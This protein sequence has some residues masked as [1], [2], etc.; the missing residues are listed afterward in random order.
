MSE[1]AFYLLK[2]C[3]MLFA[4]IYGLYATVTDFHIEVD[5]KKILSNKGKY[6]IAILLIS[7]SISNIV[8]VVNDVNENEKQKQ[9]KIENNNNLNRQLAMINGLKQQAI[10]LREQGNYEELTHKESMGQLTNLVERLSLVTQEISSTRN[11]LNRIVYPVSPIKVRYTLHYSLNNKVLLDF[12]KTLEGIYGNSLQKVNS[13]N[14]ADYDLMFGRYMNGMDHKP[15]AINEDEYLTSP[16]DNPEIEI[17]SSNGGPIEGWPDIRYVNTG[18]S[19]GY[20]TPEYKVV[21]KNELD[22]TVTSGFLKA[23]NKSE[24]I[25]SV[26]N[27][28]DATIRLR[29][30]FPVDENDIENY[31]LPKLGYTQI[32]FGD[33]RVMELNI[34]EGQFQVLDHNSKN[35]L[36][37]IKKGDVIYQILIDKNVYSTMKLIR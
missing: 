32:H 6:G 4:G 31:I 8:E 36:N 15:K 11:D 16:F 25:L 10:E 23:N 7:I 30:S 20:S 29:F 22:K 24:D 9:T 5:G 12:Y 34:Q 2:Y 19:G 1:I 28:L 27:L 18:D 3:G 35:D 33:E 17:I 21:N 14:S 13:R 26:P 37:L